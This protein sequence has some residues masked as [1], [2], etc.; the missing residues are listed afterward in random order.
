MSR[1]LDELTAFEESMA[2]RTAGMSLASLEDKDAP[3]VGLLGA[4]AWVHHKRTE[5][6]LAFETFMKRT[7]SEEIATYLFFEPVVDE[8]GFP[9]PAGPARGA[10]DDEGA[11][12][13]GDERPAE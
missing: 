4:L 7:S 9:D 6:T 1:R 2:E 11:V 10:G 5:P 8:A 12:L 3:K 13:P